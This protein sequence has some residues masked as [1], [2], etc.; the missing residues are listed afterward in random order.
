[1]NDIENYPMVFFYENRIDFRTKILPIDLKDVLFHET[2]HLYY[3]GFVAFYE[4]KSCSTRCKRISIISN[5]FRENHQDL[6][7]GFEINLNGPFIFVFFR[8]KED[9]IRFSLDM[10]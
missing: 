4:T 2:Y 8:K 5:W 9:L 7:R 1:M 10:V 6:L 3:V